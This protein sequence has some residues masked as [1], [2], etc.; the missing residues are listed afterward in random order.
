VAADEAE[1]DVYAEFEL[2]T[3]ILLPF[4]L[5]TLQVVY[6]VHILVVGKN[7]ASP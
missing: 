4:K 1:T 6:E 3:T 2:N 7:P 5:C